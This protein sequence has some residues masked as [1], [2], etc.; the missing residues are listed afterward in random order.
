MNQPKYDTLISTMPAGLER[1]ILRVL[2]KRVGRENAVGRKDLVKLIYSLGI[3]SH[4]RQV[5]E[6]IKDLRRDGHLI[7][8]AAGE[9]GGYYLAATL[10]EYHEFM[11]REFNAKISDMAETKRKLD[12][13]ARE[14]FG[15]GA[16]MRLGW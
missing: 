8:S 9:D 10:A 11:E 14:Q 3:E 15:E 5:R 4:E 1:A 2:A 12:A 6:A 16:Q 7:C 13:A